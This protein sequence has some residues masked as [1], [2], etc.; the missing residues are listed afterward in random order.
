[1]SV[2]EIN[3]DPLASFEFINV[4]SW[5]TTVNMHWG[6]RRASTA[7]WRMEGNHMA[8]QVKKKHIFQDLPMVDRALVLVK[9]Y[10]PF[11]EISDIH[12][13]NIKAICDGFTDAYLWED[14]EWAYVPFVAFMWAG[15]DE[16]KKRRTIIEVH[17][18]EGV[19]INGVSQLLPNGRTRL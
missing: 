14:D 17:E 9:V 19:F 8:H 2:I 1:M 3:G 13:V 18:L 4:P 16:A 15:I 12:N 10:P 11:E 7:D 5:N 6:R